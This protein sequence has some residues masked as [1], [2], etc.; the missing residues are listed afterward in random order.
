MK[1][2][3]SI[4]AFLALV[5]QGKIFE[6]PVSKF[7]EEHNQK[8]E[9]KARDEW[10]AKHGSVFDVVA[11]EDMKEDK[12][13]ERMYE[14]LEDVSDIP[15]YRRE[16]AYAQPATD[17]PPGKEPREYEFKCCDLVPPTMKDV[18]DDPD[19]RRELAYAEPETGID[20]NS[21]P[22][23]VVPDELDENVFGKGKYQEEPKKEKRIKEKP[24]Y[25]LG[26]RIPEVIDEKE[27][28]D[29]ILK[30]KDKITKDQKLAH[31]KIYE[32]F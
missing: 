21:I 23:E 7:I 15:S 9:E 4:V 28:T 29:Y 3:I 26:D 31:P 1:N 19:Y 8:L 17:Y 22:P 18:S 25:R 6:N 32:E 5:T 16:L 13:I 14:D 11:E 20:P 27:I 30:N 10:V 2:I 12:N 24:Y